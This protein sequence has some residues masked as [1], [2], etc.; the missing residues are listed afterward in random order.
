MRKVELWLFYANHFNGTVLDNLE[1]L[2]KTMTININAVETQELF[3]KQMY[4]VRAILSVKGLNT[5]RRV[6]F[7]SFAYG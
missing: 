3:H 2:I 1:E 4:I 7:V 5:L 6:A